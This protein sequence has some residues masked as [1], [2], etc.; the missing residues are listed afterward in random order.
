MPGATAAHRRTETRP[1]SLNRSTSENAAPQLPSVDDQPFDV[2]SLK[3]AAR[4]VELI[5][6]ANQLYGPLDRAAVNRP[7][8]GFH[9]ELRQEIVDGRVRRAECLPG[10]F[11]AVLVGTL[12]V[13]VGQ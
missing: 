9:V 8:R 11:G 10:R 4:E 2:D 12:P 7:D 6:L 13:L 3:P 5:G 1:W